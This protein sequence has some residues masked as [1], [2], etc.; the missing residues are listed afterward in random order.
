M[1]PVRPICMLFLL[2]LFAGFTTDNLMAQGRKSERSKDAPRKPVPFEK[3]LAYNN[4][5]FTI[6]SP[7]LDSGNTITVTPKGLKADNKPQTISITGKVHDVLFG[8]IDRDGWPE[9][10]IWETAADKVHSE[11]HGFTV[12]NGRFLLP[13]TT[14]NSN[15][16]DA[17]AEGHSGYDEFQIGDNA[18]MQRFP[19]YKGSK[20]TGKTRQLQY[21]LLTTDT[22]KQLW[23]EKSMDL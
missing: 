12:D 9:L 2:A 16:Q 19:V 22:Q 7:G 21:S 13:F 15:N 20:R 10:V 6:S 3:T 5:G 17:L 14:N 18:L 4:L 23:F 8:D 1:Q 11:I